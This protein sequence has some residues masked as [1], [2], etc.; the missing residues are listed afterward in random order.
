M[1]STS[2]FT[3]IELMVVVAIVGI[4]SAIAVPSYTRYVQR[5]DLVEGTQALSQYRVQMEQY[6]QD[7]GNY[8]TGGACITAPTLT[9]FT[10]TCTSANSGQTYTA[11]AT[12]KTTGMLNGFVYTI[13]QGNNQQTT[14]LPSSWGSL[15]SAASTSWIVR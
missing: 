15:T 10:L 2:G 14:G 3:L 4:L 9:N 8:G 6:Y 12:G 5:G 11:T 13:D 1:R 7:N